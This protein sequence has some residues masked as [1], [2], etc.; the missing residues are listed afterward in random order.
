MKSYENVSKSDLIMNQLLAGWYGAFA[1]GY[2]HGKSSG[3]VYQGGRPVYIPD[4]MADDLKNSMINVSID[5]IESNIE[6][7]IEDPDSLKSYMKNGHKYANNWHDP[8]NCQRGPDILS[9]IE[10]DEQHTTK[11]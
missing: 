2:V 4:K 7:F 11:K 1:I 10:V 5:N 8:I 6:Y 9:N 3:I